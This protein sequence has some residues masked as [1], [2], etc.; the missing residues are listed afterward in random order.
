MRGQS[1]AAAALPAAKG[2]YLAWRIMLLPQH[3]KPVAIPLLLP[4]AVSRSRLQEAGAGPM[5]LW[6]H[7]WSLTCFSGISSLSATLYR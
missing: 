3:L 4:P 5:V 6:A 2:P 1:A 7:P